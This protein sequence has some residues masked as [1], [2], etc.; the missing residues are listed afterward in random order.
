MSKKSKSKKSG[1]LGT[2]LAEAGVT[3][4][5]YVI[6]YDPQVIAEQTAKLIADRLRGKV[7]FNHCAEFTEEQFNQQSHP[8]WKQC[9]VRQIV[10]GDVDIGGLQASILDALPGVIG[11]R[12][13][14]F[15]HVQPTQRH[16]DTVRV[17][18]VSVRCQFE[19]TKEGLLGMLDVFIC[20]SAVRDV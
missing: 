6:P 11:N 18:H 20:M 7:L 4:A 12:F 3:A 15:A 2:A 5:R 16:G 19:P 8:H 17:R 9:Y 1:N 10:N 14:A 13:V